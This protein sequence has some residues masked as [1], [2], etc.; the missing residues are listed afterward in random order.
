MKKMM[1]KVAFVAAI[2]SV[3]VV[4]ASCQSG[5]TIDVKSR[6]GQTINTQNGYQTSLVLSQNV[7]NNGT[8]SVGTVI[9]N[10]SI[11][12]D[13]ES[14]NPVNYNLNANAEAKVTLKQNIVTVSA[15]NAGIVN[16]SEKSQATENDMSSTEEKKMSYTK[17][18]TFSDGQS[19]DAVYAYAY[20]NVSLTSPVPVPHVQITNVD[21]IDYTATQIADNQYKVVMH[22]VANYKTFGVENTTEGTLDL[23]PE[24]IQQVE[25]TAPAYTYEEVVKYHF[26]EQDPSILMEWRLTRNDGKKFSVW[27][28]VGKFARISGHNELH[29]TSGNIVSSTQKDLN[30]KE[31]CIS[32][33]S[34]SA[35][36]FFEKDEKEFHITSTAFGKEY[37]RMWMAESGKP[38]EGLGLIVMFQ[39]AD[40]TFTDPETGFTS[41]KSFSGELKIKEEK[42]VDLHKNG[43][44]VQG[45]HAP[46]INSYQFTL[47]FKLMG[48]EGYTFPFETTATTNL[49]KVGM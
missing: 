43:I 21:Y 24:Y 19:A 36:C 16:L 5:E 35:D 31:E 38:I 18:F 44:E 40:V 9:G 26:V 30:T 20:T 8:E 12:T 23:Y 13:I 41:T 33:F 15:E 6:G 25:A 14:E 22:F 27:A 29:V 37:C 17:T 39:T 34:P 49:Y 46:Y 28:T 7:V 48:P 42:A 3:S 32:T 4:F 2:V 11:T 1:K 47:E 45:K 10:G